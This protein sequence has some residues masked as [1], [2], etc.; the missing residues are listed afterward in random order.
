VLPEVTK[1]E[2]RDFVLV[3]EPG[4]GTGEQDLASM[5]DRTDPGSAMD[6]H[7]EIPTRPKIGLGSVHPHAHCEAATVGPPFGL[8]RLLCRDGRRD[9]V[10]RSVEGDEEALALRV[11]LVASVGVDCATDQLTVAGEHVAVCMAE[12][13][14]HARRSLHVGEQERDRA[15]RKPAHHG[16]MV[17]PGG[18]RANPVRRLRR[19]FVVDPVR[20]LGAAPLRLPELEHGQI[21]ASRH[22]LDTD[23]S[24]IERYVVEHGDGDDTV[25]Q[26]DEPAGGLCSAASGRQAL[27]DARRAARVGRG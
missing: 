24:H 3:D 12:P 23:T 5:P 19:A 11:D 25:G 4:G 26:G 8:V 13:P 18:R 10:L 14:E 22:D 2:A 27:H 6:A 21:V 7:A 15:D 17:A 20:P 9:G 1:L 16:L